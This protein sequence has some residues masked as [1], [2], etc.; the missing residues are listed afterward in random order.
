M[1]SVV[2]F[3]WAW[4]VSLTALTSSDISSI[5]MN[6]PTVD[7]SS[8]NV[9]LFVFF[10]C[11]FDWFCGRGFWL[12]GLDLGCSGRRGV[13]IGWLLRFDL[14]FIGDSSRKNLLINKK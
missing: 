3:S 8:L 7:L 10:G 14:G 4:V 13:V 1:L 9:T 6:T 12:V 2:L 11:L 5:V